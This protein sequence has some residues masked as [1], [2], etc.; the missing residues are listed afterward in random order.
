MPPVRARILLHLARVAKP[1]V[2]SPSQIKIIKVDGLAEKRTRPRS[3]TRQREK[4]I[5]VRFL[6]TEYEVLTARA[7]ETGLTPGTYVRT[8]ALGSAGPR[9]RRSPTI[10]R[11][12]AAQ[13]IAELNKAGSNL[14]QI[15]HALNIGF[16]PEREDVKKSAAAVKQA[17]LQIL[18]AFGYKT[19][20]R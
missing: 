19:Y 18:K 8:C 2:A 1:P 14:N 12:L 6:D 5:T 9:A 7:D 11:E 17:A 3:E 16:Q 15:A 13:A 4:R 10:D 20:D